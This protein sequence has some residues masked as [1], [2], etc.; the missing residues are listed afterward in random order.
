MCGFCGIVGPAYL[1]AIEDLEAM[2]RELVHRGPDDLGTWSARFGVASGEHAVALGHT[3]LSILDLSALGHQPM[4][5]ADGSVTISYNGEIYNFREL[6]EELRA[7]GHT[8]C[9]ETDTEVLLTAYC[10]W[11]VEAFTRLIGMFAFAI[12]DAPKR[13]LLLVRDRLGIKPLY[14]CIRDGV[15]TFGSELRALRRHRGFEPRIDRGTL[16]RYLRYGYVTGVQTIYANVWQVM[17]GEYLLWEDGKI[18]TRPYWRLIEETEVVP[19]ASFEAAVDRLEDLLGDAVERRLIADVPLGAFLS[20]GVDS[21][22]VVALMRERARGEVRTFSIGFR[23]RPYDEAPF[24]RRVAKHL[25]TQ[26]T[27]IYVERHQ[28][29]SVAHELP[30]LYDEPFADESAIPTTL[31][32]RL[33]RNHVTVALSGDGGDEIFGGYERYTKFSQ[34]LPLFALPRTVRRLLAVAAPLFPR[35]S[36]RN[37][38]SHLMADDYLELAERLHSHFTTAE[39]RAGCGEEGACPSEIF[40]DT[41]AAAPTDDPIV[42]ARFGDC[43]MYL[44]DDILTKVDRASMSVALEVRVPILDHRV[45]QFGMGLPRSLVWYGGE[46]KAPLRAVLYR[47]V[48]RELIERPKH[49]FGIPIEMLLAQELAEWPKRFLEPARLAEEGIFRPDGVALLLARARSR[50]PIAVRRLWFLLCFQRWFAR[51]HRG[52]GVG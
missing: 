19:P 31:L 8:F 45:V 44:C 25:G 34:L 7:G 16:G 20:G 12:W 38:L 23:E 21:S 35:R 3:R 43:R 41:F 50:E 42:R 36:V 26:H 39:L 10:A 47:R 28:A 14:Y 27:E 29:L 32:C 1:A 11:G 2:T 15:L 48:P 33:T 4:H 46:T 17:P 24:A 9:S 5:T 52:E 40:A 22:V 6:R 18:E 37:G 30:T 49:G 13:R 51:V